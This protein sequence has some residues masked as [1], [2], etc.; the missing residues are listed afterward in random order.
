MALSTLQQAIQA[1]IQ[2]PHSM[3]N[4]MRLTSA[5]VK[6]S[7]A[8]FVRT[9]TWTIKGLVNPK[10]RRAGRDLYTEA[11]V[12]CS[13]ALGRLSLGSDELNSFGVAQRELTHSRGLEELK[14]K[15]AAEGITTVD[16]NGLDRSKALKH[17]G[18]R[19]RRLSQKD[20]ALLRAPGDLR[21]LERRAEA[22][23]STWSPEVLSPIARS[24]FLTAV[25]HAAERR[26]RK[27]LKRLD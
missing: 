11:V 16:I 24:S 26:Q 20:L 19:N 23:A 21:S 1:Q 6:S 22:E 17:L 2:F 13:I 8:T 4:L 5:A 3:S 10:K 9:S 27:G 18:D 14:S 7:S 15:W 12:A 25:D